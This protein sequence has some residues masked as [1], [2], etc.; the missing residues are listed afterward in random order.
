M[1]ETAEGNILIFRTPDGEWGE[2]TNQYVAPFNYMGNRFE[3]VEQFLYYMRAIFGRSQ[4]TA[5]KILACGGDSSALTKTSKKQR[6]LETNTWEAVRPQI[7]R[8]GMRQKFLQNPDL[9]KKLLS[10]GCRLLVEV[11][12]ESL[13]ERLIPG[14]DDWYLHP[15]KW[16]NRNQ[17]GKALMQVRADLRCADRL[18]GPNEAYVFPDEPFVLRTPLGQMNLREIS[19]LPGAREAV[20]AYAETAQQYLPLVIATADDF[21]NRKNLPLVTLERA[22]ARNTADVNLALSRAK[23]REEATITEAGAPETTGAAA[24]FE[25]PAETAADPTPAENPE[26]PFEAE[27][28]FEAPG[29]I[30]LSFGAE[31][32]PAAEAAANDS[33]SEA[34]N[35]AF[36]AEAESGIDA[37]DAGAG[38]AA[39]P[40]PEIPDISHAAP[41]GPEGPADQAGFTAPVDPFIPADSDD[42]D[43]DL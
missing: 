42:P 30:S 33:G 6:I 26:A 27:D 23:A 10:T 28:S 1:A 29:S 43:K 9:R 34:E 19:V 40:I 17:T 11:P 32:D 15:G 16:K 22:I 4:A 38:D 41:A 24:S 31:S 20:C 36:G 3:T 35:G 5:E 39:D 37:F 21:I 18:V 8:R 2:F 25:T 12:K 13:L 7:M 14:N